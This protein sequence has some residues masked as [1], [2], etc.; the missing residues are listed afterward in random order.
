MD[1]YPVIAATTETVYGLIGADGILQIAVA[2]DVAGDAWT[3]PRGVYAY[4]RVLRD[5]RA[6][7]SLDALLGD[8]GKVNLGPRF[9]ES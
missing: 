4:Y 8:P 5:H 1:L 9:R 3:L 6:L 2:H 7:L